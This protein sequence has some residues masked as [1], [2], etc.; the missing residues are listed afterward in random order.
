MGPPATRSNLRSS[1]SG[2][3]AGPLGAPRFM[4]RRRYQPCASRPWRPS[5]VAGL[6]RPLRRGSRCPAAAPSRASSRALA[7]DEVARLLRDAAADGAAVALIS[8]SASSREKRSRL[9]GDHEASARSAGLRAPPPSPRAVDAG[10]AQLLDHRAVLVEREELVDAL[11][12]RQADAGDRRRCPP[13]TR[14]SARPCCR[15]GCASSRRRLAADVAD[16]EREEHARQRP[17]LAR[18][19]RRPAGCRR[20][21]R[22]CAPA[23]AAL[24]LSSAGRGRRRPARARLASAGA[25]QRLA[26]A[27]DVHRA[28]ADEV[29]EQAEALRR[30]RAVRAVAYIASP[31]GRDDRRAAGRAVRSASRTRCSSPVRLLSTGPTTCGMTSPARWTITVSP[32]RMSLRR[33]SSSL[34]SVA[35]FTVAPPICT[36]SS[37]AKG[38]SAPVRPTFTSM[39]QQLRRRLRRRELVRD[40]PARLAADGAQLPLQRRV[41]D[42][43]RRCRRSRSRATRAGRSQPSQNAIDLFDRLEAPDVRVDPEAQLP[44]PLSASQC[45][46]GACRLPASRAG[47][48]RRRAAARR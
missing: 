16:A 35:S 29:L 31:S 18:L 36:G 40:R 42:L 43:D 1:G 8:D 19:D 46:R 45:V 48:G 41:V 38:F 13:A 22:P 23:P 27:V 4:G 34:C 11:G 12:D 14:P 21:S 9:P 10:R 28:A 32:A 25:R 2:A 44:Q 7:D 24:A 39:S 6:R 26:D 15:S 17:L 37:T 30:A 5:P 3:R 20:S 47:T 33:M